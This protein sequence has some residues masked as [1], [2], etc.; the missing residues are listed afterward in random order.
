[1][2]K[3]GFD[4][5][6]SLLGFLILVPLF[7]IVGVLIKLDSKGP[8]FYLQS[9]VGRFNRDFKLIKFRTMRPNADKE[10]LITTSSRDSRITKIGYYLRKFKID[11]LPQLLNVVK[12]DMSLVG[13]R[14]EVR[15]YV[16]L[17]T[18][19]QA[20]VLNFR[21]GITDVSSVV[22]SNENELLEGIENPEKYYKEVL[23]P[24]KIKRNLEY[25]ENR[26]LLKD[27]GVILSTFGKILR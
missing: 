11:E 3:R 26:N 20:K 24:D 5:F 8:I 2:F 22:Y 14:P 7:A 12:G 16:D 4:F 19:E 10:G 1:M 23:M 9:R 27:I 21:P 17:Y 6:S 25:L 15:K 18:S 13:P